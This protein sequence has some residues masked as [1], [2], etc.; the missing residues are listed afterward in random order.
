MSDNEWTLLH[1]AKSYEEAKKFATSKYNVC[2][3]RRSDLKNETKYSFKCSQYRKYSLCTFQ[4]K[5]IV[6]DN[7]MQSI[8]IMSRNTHQHEENERNPTTRL[9]S[10]VRQSV[11]N[12]VKC[13]L[14]ETQ[15]KKSLAI[16]HTQTSIDEIK[17]HSLI[18]YE[19]RKDRPEIFSVY[20]LRKWCYEHREGKDLHSTFVPFYK[21]DDINNVYVFFT[22]KQ[23]FQQIQLT[24]F[25]QVDATYK[26]NWNNL[27]LLV[28]GSTDANRH[29]KPFGM[30]LISNDENTE[31]FNHL[32]N[33]INSLALQEFNQSCVIN[34]IM[35][36]GAPGKIQVIN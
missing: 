18:T 11:S 7:N 23:L 4:I 9:P 20:D 5:I 24:T 2:L 14:T 36:D 29:F 3:Y 8:S 6:T 13:G 28:F 10:P 32:F 34:Q 27:P 22:T 26:L 15:I 30:A 35:A 21:V 25:L 19:R 17:L 16:N 12:Y 1:I 31:C 33:S